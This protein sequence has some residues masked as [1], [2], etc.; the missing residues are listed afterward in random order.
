M[1]RIIM[2]N[3]PELPVIGTLY[4]QASKFISSFSIHGYSQLEVNSLDDFIKMKPSKDDIV[5][6]SDHGISIDILKVKDS[7]LKFKDLD[8]VFILWFFHNYINTIP[9]PKRWILTGEHFRKTPQIDNHLK[10]WHIQNSIS[11][12]VPM[13]FATAIL[14]VHIG[15]Y[16]RNEVIKASFVGAPYQIEWCRKLVN[17]D[18]LVYVRYTPPFISEADRYGIYLSSVV[19]LGFH[20]HENSLNSVL[21]E[22]VFEGLALGN[23]VISDNP[24][25]EEFTDGN[26]K[27]VSSLELVKEEI[28]RMWIDKNEREKRQKKGMNWCKNNGTYVTVSKAFIEKALEV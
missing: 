15:Q 7:F 26:V 22:R 5:Y 12:Y 19:S 3:T 1:K 10:S 2:L 6:I 27:Y 28:D 16:K 13:T 17:E 23:V 25:C 20:S 4:F 18:N 11:N 9:M 8:C 24:V 14:P 21:V